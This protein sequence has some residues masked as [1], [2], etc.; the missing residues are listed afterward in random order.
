MAW[1][2]SAKIKAPRGVRRDLWVGYAPN[3]V[4]RQKPNVKALLLA[5]A[6]HL[7]LG[8]LEA[9]FRFGAIAERMGKPGQP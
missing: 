7:G 8:H 4:G 5:D 9:V 6:T 1:R 3:G 2:G